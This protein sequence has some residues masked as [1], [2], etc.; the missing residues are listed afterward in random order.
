MIKLYELN[1]PKIDTIKSLLFKEDP[2]EIEIAIQMPHIQFFNAY[3]NLADDFLFAAFAG[4]E[5]S[6]VSKKIGYY[7]GN[8]HTNE[9]LVF[10][11]KPRSIDELAEKVH[12]VSQ[13]FDNSI[14][15][16]DT[17]TD[18]LDN[19]VEYA[20]RNQIAFPELFEQY[21]EYFEMARESEND[22]EA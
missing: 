13:F 16:D 18:S 8:S 14:A 6:R 4:E 20:E 3:D 2:L 21:Q 5:F 1:R 19:F 17:I 15:T 12:F 9:D 22:D 10:E 11:I 7:G